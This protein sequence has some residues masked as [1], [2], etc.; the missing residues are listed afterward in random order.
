MKLG[1]L[2]CP[3]QFGGNMKTT[4]ALFGILFFVTNLALAHDAQE[5]VL[6]DYIDIQMA[7]VKDLFVDAQKAAKLLVKDTEDWLQDIT[8]TDPR[9][10]DIQKA[11]DAGTAIL[12]LAPSKEKEI[13]DQFEQVS[14]GLISLIRKDS[15]L[16]SEWQLY[17]CPMVKK[18]WA[19][20]KTDPTLMNP[21][22]GLA[23][24][25]CGTKKP[26]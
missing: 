26:W 7:L 15:T 20:P 23:M 22:M 3:L 16:K 25:Q 17:Y 13:R 9:R 11:F 1:Q 21:Y 10:P 6:Q 14:N 5:E 12:A 2:D 24:Q 4:L 8:A 19:Q 18:F